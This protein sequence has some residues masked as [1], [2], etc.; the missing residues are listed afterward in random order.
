MSLARKQHIFMHN[1]IL[2]TGGAGFVGSS[3]ALVLKR[4]FPNLKIIALDNLHRRGSELNLPRLAAADIRF[5]HGDIRSQ[6]DL[7]NLPETFDL[8]IECSAEPSAQAGYDGSPEYLIQ[9]NLAGC[10]HCLELARRTGSDFIFL[11]TSRVYPMEKLN[12]L[13]L[14]EEETRFVLQDEQPF[15][16]ASRYGISECFP[17]DGTRSLYGMTK[18]SAELMVAEYAAAYG[19]RCVVNRCGLIAGP[20]QMGK[21]DQGV[22]TYWMTA[23]YLRRELNYIGFGGQ[24][25][26]V[27]DLLHVDDLAR[28]IAEQVSDM[29]RYAGKM[30]NVGGGLSG[31][32][33][34][35]EIT[36]L[37]ERVTGNTILIGTRPENR[38]ADIPIYI[39]DHRRLT[40]FSGWQP[41]LTAEDICAD[42]YRWLRENEAA[43]RT[44]LTV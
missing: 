40:E 35:R 22:V 33:S 13:C 26:Q 34:L 2:V 14:R 28:L 19:L 36:S 29:D 11:S 20:W 30:F 8:I 12:A 44:C 5:I 32:L 16:G 7:Q 41:S 3:L 4:Q 38:P 42:I 24:G 23:H 9:T 18:L 39:T 37:C 1:S 17:L 6:G 15:L 43:L 25:K 21:T 31:S 10:F 27:R